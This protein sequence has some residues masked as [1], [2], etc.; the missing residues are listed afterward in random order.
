MFQDLYKFLGR[1]SSPYTITYSNKTL[2]HQMIKG[3]F[4]FPPPAQLQNYIYGGARRLF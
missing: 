2:I 1:G 4:P 3:N